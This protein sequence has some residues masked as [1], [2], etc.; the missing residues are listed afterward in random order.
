MKTVF[1]WSYGLLFLSGCCADPYKK[2]QIINESEYHIDVVCSYP[3]IYNNI[4]Y[5]GVPPDS[6]VSCNKGNDIKADEISVAISPGQG[7]SAS[8]KVNSK[9]CFNERE[10]NSTD[11]CPDY[12]YYI[13]TDVVIGGEQFAISTVVDCSEENRLGPESSLQ[14]NPIE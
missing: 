10:Y 1:C 4:T 6:V 13:C 3:G 2:H 12:G 7:I 14:S 5:A 9:C 8:F 11:H